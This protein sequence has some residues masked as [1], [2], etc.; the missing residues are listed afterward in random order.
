MKVV[1]LFYSKKI[2]YGAN[3]P[4]CDQF[5]LNKG[6]LQGEVVMILS[7]YFMCWYI[8]YYCY[9]KK[10]DRDLGYNSTCQLLSSD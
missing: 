3:L 4:I 6:A 5:V 10:E 2:F 8:F 9:L 1:L 7:G